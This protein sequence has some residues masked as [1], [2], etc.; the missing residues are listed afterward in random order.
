MIENGE[1]IKTERDALMRQQTCGKH[2]HTQRNVWW[3]GK[4][5]FFFYKRE[6]SAN[7]WDMRNP[8]R[9]S[10]ALNAKVVSVLTRNCCCADT[11]IHICA[12]IWNEKETDRESCMC[13]AIMCLAD[14][15]DKW[16]CSNVY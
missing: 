1:Q 10:W 12:C 14:Q 6:R 8:D 16:Q 7:K 4:E 9:E 13:W 3:K 2:I 5:N 15:G 11:E